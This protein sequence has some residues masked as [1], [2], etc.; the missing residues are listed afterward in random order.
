[1][2]NVLLLKCIYWIAKYTL[3]KFVN[4]TIHIYLLNALLSDNYLLTQ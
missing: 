4:L 2:K 1:M 3:V